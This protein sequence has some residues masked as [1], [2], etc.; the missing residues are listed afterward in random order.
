[1][2][3]MTYNVAEATGLIF[4]L[5]PQSTKRGLFIHLRV[6]PVNCSENARQVAA[7]AAPVATS[8]E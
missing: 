8:L 7:R 5:A 4:G 3:E 6:A 1:M 2:V